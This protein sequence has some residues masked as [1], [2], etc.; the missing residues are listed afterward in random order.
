[1]QEVQVHYRI[2][3]GRTGNTTFLPQ[4]EQLARQ[5]LDKARLLLYPEEKYG[6]KSWA[7]FHRF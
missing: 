7:D 6:K 2:A 1:M 5:F 3:D 4:V